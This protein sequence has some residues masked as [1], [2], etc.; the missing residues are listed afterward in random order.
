MNT[1]SREVMKSRA[2]MTIA[3]CS[4]FGAPALR[5]AASM[6]MPMPCS[7]RSYGAVR[8]SFGRFPLHASKLASASST[9]MITNIVLKER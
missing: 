9:P 1:P 5:S 7:A 8:P 3:W 2:T 4:G 6:R